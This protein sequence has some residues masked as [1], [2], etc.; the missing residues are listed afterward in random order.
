VSP[1]RATAPKLTAQV[2]A[3]GPGLGNQPHLFQTMMPTLC[4]TV[5]C[6]WV[7]WTDAAS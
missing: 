3:A 2:G 5:L 1:E 6:D 7:S 4:N